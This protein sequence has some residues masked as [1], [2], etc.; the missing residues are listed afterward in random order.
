LNLAAEDALRTSTVHDE[1]NEIC[2]LP[3][4]L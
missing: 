2:G 1:E 4:Q 3:T